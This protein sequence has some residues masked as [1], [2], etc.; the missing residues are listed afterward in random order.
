MP[1]IATGQ[2]V[3][4]GGQSLM[5]GGGQDQM[6]DV[7]SVRQAETSL[8]PV[9]ELGATGLKRATGYVDEEFLPQLRGRKAVGVFKE[10]SENDPLVSSLL[11]TITNLLTNVEWTVTPGGKDK[12]STKAAKLVEECM[13][14]MSHTWDDFVI[15]ALSCL[16][17]GWS[18]HEVVYKRR[19]GMKAPEARR[20]KFSDGL[21]GWAKVP[22]RAQETLVRWI[23]DE[24]GDCIGMLQM[25][26][27]FYR[28]VFLPRSKCVLFNY[29]TR[30][31]NPEGQSLLRG[32]YRPWYF[33]K[34]IEELE[35]IGV[36]RDLA[37]LPIVKVPAEY[38]AAP[39]GSKQ[40]K[41]VQSMRAMVKGLRRNEQEGI[42]FPTAYDQDTRQPMFDLSLLG[43]GGGRA[44]ST[45]GII[46][47]YEQRILMAVLADFIMVGHQSVGSYSL[48]TDK[49]G[50]FRTALNSIVT[51]LAETMNREMVKPLMR[52]NGLPIESMPEITPTDV[53]SPDIGQ[54]G[55]F[56]TA[57]GSLG[58]SWFPDPEM[59]AFV[60]KTARLPQRDDESKDRERV[61]ARQAD[62]VRF[63]QKQTEFIQTQQ[64]LQAAQMGPQQID[65]ATGQPVPPGTPGAQPA[66]GGQPPAAPGQPPGGPG[67]AQTPPGEKSPP[68]Q[69]PG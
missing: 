65:P 31:G 42:V 33:K 15:E 25:A 64:A 12:A 58:V 17:Y 46:Q 44:F 16:V 67:G 2:P 5:G 43:S 27:P 10:M 37:G 22:I 34:R 3:V 14:D 49:T 55:G 19:Q 6:G 29:R 11:F 54:L 28:Q 68:G 13:E 56:M 45:D 21:V 26:P 57:M 18:W 50:I 1:D 41:T 52:L 63:M 23:F 69:P 32:M 40:A 38:L 35:S 4:P 9:L 47:R 59:E 36:E 51:S 39:A 8:D 20:S 66:P 24:T 60:R 53:D 30:K 61:I 48:H 62:L 7:V